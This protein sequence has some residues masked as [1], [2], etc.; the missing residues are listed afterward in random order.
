M[1]ASSSEDGPSVLDVLEAEL[2]RH[3]VRASHVEAVAPEY[4]RNAKDRP[5]LYAVLHDS[6]LEV[7]RARGAV[8]AVRAE[9]WGYELLVGRNR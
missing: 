4:P 5:L 9:H 2:V 3:G 7:L 1:S 8:Y 6:L